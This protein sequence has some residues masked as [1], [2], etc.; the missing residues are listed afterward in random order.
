VG[1]HEG[2]GVIEAVGPGVTRVK[3]GDHVVCSFLPVCGHCRFC[4]TGQP[5]LCDA[6]L[7][8]DEGYMLDGTYRFHAKGHDVGTTCRLGTFSQ[9]SV[10]SE[11]AVVKIDESIPLEVACLT[12][13]GVPTGWSSAVRG[14]DVTPGDIVVI[15]GCGGVGANAVQGASYAGAKNIVVVDPVAFKR[16]KAR[17]LGATHV[18]AN[19]EAAK[20]IVF[21]L[22]NGVWA[23]KAIVTV[24]LVDEAVVQNA[25]DITR[26]GG[27]VVV[28]ALSPS[29]A[30]TI[31]VPGFVLTMW[32]KTIRG[33]A[34]GSANFQTDIPNLL[35]LYRLGQ[36]KLDEL[37]TTRY[38]LEQINQI[39]E[40]MI[41]GKN[42]RGVIIHE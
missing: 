34:A 5:S 12:G 9:Y 8:M 29:G 10:V 37:I 22:T 2:A 32:E 41:A 23:D 31:Q 36:L 20:E 11:Y 25:F 4:V 21:G 3:P 1:G 24:G 39:F 28:T 35:S 33:V 27:T 14:A 30:K 38:K 26:K 17:E 19:A 40:D 42:I 6:A 7:N 15:Y 18:A 16:E 13:C